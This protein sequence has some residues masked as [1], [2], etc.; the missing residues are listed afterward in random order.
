M[1]PVTQ[2][3]FSKEG[4]CFPACI[5]SILEIPLGSIPNFCVEYPSDWLVETNRWLGK[6]HGFA[7]ILIQALGEPDQLPAFA[8]D[9]Y[10]IMSGPAERGLQHSVVGRNGIMVHDP[11]PSGAGLTKVKIWDFFVAVDPE[12]KRWGK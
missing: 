12:G 8:T 2:T 4:N 1:K 9:V 7:L 6:N 5:A 3:I 10:H 11:H